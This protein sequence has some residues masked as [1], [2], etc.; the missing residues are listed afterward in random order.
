MYNGMVE[1]FLIIPSKDFMGFCFVFFWLS[2]FCVVQK[3]KMAPSQSQDIFLTYTSTIINI[4]I[5][6]VMT[7][8]INV[9]MAKQNCLVFSS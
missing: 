7:R 8:H 5:I 4:P 3:S 2:V 6:F 9:E 1:M